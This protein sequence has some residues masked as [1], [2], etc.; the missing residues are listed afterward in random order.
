MKKEQ[1]IMKKEHF[2]E[3]INLYGNPTLIRKNKIVKIEVIT[4]PSSH[5]LYQIAIYYYEGEKCSH[6]Y[7]IEKEKKEIMEEYEKIK[8]EL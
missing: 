8:G 6:L 7:S 4:V 3:V 2:L 5:Y 1:I